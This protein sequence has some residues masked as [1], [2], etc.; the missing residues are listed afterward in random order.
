MRF[1]KYKTQKGLSAIEFV[2]VMPLVFILMAAVIELGVVMVNYQILTK[3]V[4]NGALY[5]ANEIYFEYKSVYPDAFQKI[6][7]VVVTGSTS[8]L[9]AGCGET[10]DK[11]LAQLSESD[12]TPEVSGDYVNVTAVYHYSPIVYFGVGN[13]DGYA[14][15]LSA[16]TSVRMTR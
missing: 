8:N 3:L 16:T 7:C 1:C 2:I 4:Q 13:S 10:D 5:A 11:P 14:I 15:D 12:V 6:K 9:T